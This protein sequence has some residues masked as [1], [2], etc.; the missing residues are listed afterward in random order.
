MI[1]KKHH[2]NIESTMQRIFA[3]SSVVAEAEA[4]KIN[5]EAKYL[6]LKGVN[7]AKQTDANIAVQQQML[8]M[9]TQLQSTTEALLPIAKNK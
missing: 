7:E 3:E 9:M 5:A 4:N 6:R 1:K 2:D 8:A